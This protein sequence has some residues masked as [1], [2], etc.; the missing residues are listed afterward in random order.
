MLQNVAK[1]IERIEYI[2]WNLFMVLIFYILKFSL[3][4][5]GASIVLTW[6]ILKLE[7]RGIKN[8]FKRYPIV[9]FSFFFHIIGWIVFMGLGEF[10]R[11]EIFCRLY[12]LGL[13]GDVNDYAKLVMYPM[14]I[15]SGIMP[16]YGSSEIMIWIMP[17][18]LLLLMLPA[19]VIFFQS[20]FLLFPLVYAILTQV[21]L[22]IPL[23]AFVSRWRN[24]HDRYVKD[25]SLYSS[26]RRKQG[27][28]ERIN[29]EAYV[30]NEYQR[31]TVGNQY[32]MQM[33][34]YTISSQKKTRYRELDPTYD[35]VKQQITDRTFEIYH[36]YQQL[37]AQWGKNEKLD[38]LYQQTIEANND[39]QQV[40]M[41]AVEIICYTNNQ[42]EIKRAY[43]DL[44]KELII[45]K[46]SQTNLT[47]EIK[48]VYGV[49]V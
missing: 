38:R 41:E 28:F 17:F 43:D 35:K 25:E 37:I 13:C 16:E 44:K 39:M 24:K 15:F 14:E 2:M 33:E 27:Q 42:P 9:F 31:E 11:E 8:S 6:K 29:E 18:L 26:S 49:K 22:G 7:S 45:V 1:Y 5:F 40:Y 23:N 30:E 10:Y 36:A 19:M 12:T 46:N 48:R 47:E 32:G 21:I 4:I 20:I 3:Y 34:T